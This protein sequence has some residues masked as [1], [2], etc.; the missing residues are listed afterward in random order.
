MV[1]NMR[2]LEQYDENYS[3]VLPYVGFPTQGGETDVSAWDQYIFF[4]LNFVHEMDTCS[5]T[6]PYGRLKIRYRGTP[7]SAHECSIVSAKRTVRLTKSSRTRHKIS[8][9]EK[10]VLVTW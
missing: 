2:S 9:V 4:R 3:S 5:D 8:R 10:I 7:W 6:C 1:P